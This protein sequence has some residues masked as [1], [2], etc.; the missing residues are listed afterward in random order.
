MI[1]YIFNNYQKLLNFP[2]IQRDFVKLV[3][4]YSHKCKERY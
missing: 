1:F 4:D 2:S 3:L